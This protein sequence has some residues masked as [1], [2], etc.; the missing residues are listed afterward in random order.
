MESISLKFVVFFVFCIIIV[1]T[2]IHIVDHLNF[3]YI[4]SILIKTPKLK[5]TATSTL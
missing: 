1:Q 4:I 3:P 5:L 2:F